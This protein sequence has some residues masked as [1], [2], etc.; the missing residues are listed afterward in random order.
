MREARKPRKIVILVLIAACLGGAA[1]LIALPRVRRIVLRGSPPEVPQAVFARLLHPELG[2]RWWF[3][4]LKHIRQRLE[5]IPWVGRVAVR[6]RWP[7]ILVVSIVARRPVARWNGIDL[8]DANG[9]AFT[10]LRLGSGGHLPHLAGPPNALDLVFSEF[11][12]WW[13]LLVR[14]GLRPVSLRMDARGGVKLRLVG[15]QILRLGAR[16][17]TS[18]LRLFLEAALPVL[19][20]RWSRV[21]YVDLRYP[22]GFAV[23][24]RPT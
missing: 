3:V 1:L 20:T 13:P 21:R 10:L 12:R 16:D 7:G 9:H 22:N 8:V 5:R 24:W 18:R 15:G 6:R 11:R 23:G 17:R 4:S 19:R 14:A 2:E